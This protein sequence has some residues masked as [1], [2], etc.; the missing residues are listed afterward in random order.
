VGTVWTFGDREPWQWILGLEEK[1]FF[2][3]ARASNESKYQIIFYAAMQK[4]R[5]YVSASI[6]DRL[7]NDRRL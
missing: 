1:S 2:R 4:L 5:N 3:K 7:P 6:L